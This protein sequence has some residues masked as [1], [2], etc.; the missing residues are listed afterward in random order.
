MKG[1]T[2]PLLFKIQQ[3]YQQRRDLG[4]RG[5]DYTHIQRQINII[6]ANLLINNPALPEPM[7]ASA[8][9]VEPID[10][11]IDEQI[12][13][14][15]MRVV[16]EVGVSSTGLP[17]RFSENPTSIGKKYTDDV[18]L[19]YVI[20]KSRLNRRKQP[21][22]LT[23]EERKKR[24]VMISRILRAADAMIRNRVTDSIIRRYPER[25]EYQPVNL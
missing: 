16:S 18:V 12:D 9:P 6:F 3:L 5:E 7:P 13:N 21:K 14:P 4:S 23:L 1:L 15:N 2:G 19:N 25:V 22:P 11:Q 20:F 17:K 10:E 24:G 8:A